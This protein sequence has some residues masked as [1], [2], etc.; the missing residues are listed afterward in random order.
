[1][2][3]KSAIIAEDKFVEIA[4][5][6]PAAQAVIRAE[7]PSL[8]QCEDPMNPRQLDMPRHLAH[9][10][11]IVPVVGQSRIGRVTVCEQ[12]GSAL[13]VGSHESFDRRGGVVGDHGEANAARTRIEIF[14]VLAPRL[15]LIDVVIDHLDGAHDKDFSNI[16]GLKECITFAEGHFRLIDLDDS[17]QRFAIRIDHRS[18]LLR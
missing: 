17:L 10:A 7:P 12:R 9:H 3:V 6:M 4:V 18:A 8:Q 15:G 2:P 16:D 13:H 11:R 14:R 1:M 5:N